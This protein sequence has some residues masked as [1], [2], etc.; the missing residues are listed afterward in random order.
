M[1]GVEF[2]KKY[3]EKLG[4]PFF[5]TKSKGNG[6]GLMVCQKIISEHNGHI[7]VESKQNVG[8][9]FKINIPLDKL[10]FH[11]KGSIQKQQSFRK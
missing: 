11:Y 2:Q 10:G 5:S 1:K 9:T 8:T 6:L 4:N 7:L 3:L